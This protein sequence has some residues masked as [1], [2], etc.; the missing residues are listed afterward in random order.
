MHWG[1]KDALP[2]AAPVYKRMRGAYYWATA[3]RDKAMSKWEEATKLA[4]QFGTKVEEGLLHFEIGRH[5]DYRA[6]G[7][8]RSVHLEAANTLFSDAGL[9]LVAESVASELGVC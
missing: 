4:V 5:S 7:N 2:V 3:K 8:M 9:T 1:E 6:S